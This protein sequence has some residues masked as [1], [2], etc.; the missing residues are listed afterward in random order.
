[1]FL[2][3]SRDAGAARLDVFSGEQI[4]FLLFFSSNGEA[5]SY[6]AFILFHEIKPHSMDF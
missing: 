5:C 6:F 2:Y 3:F 1:M 4:C